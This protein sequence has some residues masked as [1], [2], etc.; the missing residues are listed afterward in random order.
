MAAYERRACEHGDA[1]ACGLWGNTLAVGT[2][3]T[4]A[5]VPGALVQWRRG[6]EG[7]HGPSCFAVAR[8]HRLGPAPPDEPVVVE[9]LAAACEHGQQQACDGAR[10]L[11]GVLHPAQ[12]RATIRE[13]VPRVQRCYNAALGQAPGTAGELELRLDVDGTGQ[14]TAVEISRNTTGSTELAPCVV[15][16]VA[17]IRFPAP[18]G[19]APLVLNYPLRFTPEDPRSK[20]AEDP[21]ATN[22]SRPPPPPQRVQ[23][24]PSPR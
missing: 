17:E 6:C 12:V 5:D 2:P 7:G 13:Y 21:D 22:G 8:A 4:P 24:P 19:N 9:F 11:P 15:A 23:P 18:R 14:V 16:A 20:Q 10:A 1:V 3:S